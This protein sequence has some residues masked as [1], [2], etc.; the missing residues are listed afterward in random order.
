M[1]FSGDLSADP[2]GVAEYDGPDSLDFV[3]ESGV[4]IAVFAAEQLVRID[5][6]RREMIARLVARDGAPRDVANRGVRLG[7]SAALK[8]GEHVAGEL[9]ARAEALVHQFPVMLEALSGGRTTEKHTQV[10]VNAMLGVEPEFHDRIVPEAVRLAET[11]SVGPFRRE[12]H[13]L[14]E[15]VRAVT[16]TERHEKALARRR[17]LVQRDVDGMAWF[18]QYGPEVEAQAAFTRHTAMA[19]AIAARPG[20]TRSLDQIRADIVGDLLIDGDTTAVPAEARGIRATVAVTVPAL[21]LLG[22]AQEGAAPATV[23]GIGP[24]PIEKARELCGGADGWMRVLT[25]PETG[26][27]LSVG[28]E[29][30]TSPPS[31]RKLVKWRAERC[32]GPGCGVP[33]SRCEIDHTIAWQDGGTTSLQ[34]LAPL[35]K[36]HHT[37]KHHGGWTVAQIE[38]SGGALEWRSPAGRTYR[39]EPTRRVPVFRPTD[40]SDAPF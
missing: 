27:V 29:R 32:M 21:T 16:L 13:A 12:L 8:V 25:H 3:V 23:E 18:M 17:V 5:G 11:E 26:I 37:V 36:G 30:Y 6:L 38:G 28:R 10:F 33:A 7:L 2:G 9:L 31:L 20:E 22:S 35:C 40:T 24:I 15:T 19:K 39:V 1:S 4:M 14:I 34:N